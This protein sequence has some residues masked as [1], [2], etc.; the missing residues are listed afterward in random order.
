MP[1]LM[2]VT[3]FC[4]KWNGTNSEPFY[5][6]S[7]IYQTGS[8]R[9]KHH[10]LLKVLQHLT[11]LLS[12]IQASFVG[13]LCFHV[14]VVIEFMTRC[15]DTKMSFE[16][17]TPPWSSWGSQIVA[18]DQSYQP[19]RLYPRNDHHRRIVDRWGQQLSCSL[20]LKVEV[21]DLWTDI[22]QNWLG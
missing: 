11:R 10:R 4:F 15:W 20:W 18:E 14:F 22:W 3:C 8:H 5:V 7:L 2:L 17:R 6:I 16:G 12:S 1:A 19:C 9:H 21:S 13:Q